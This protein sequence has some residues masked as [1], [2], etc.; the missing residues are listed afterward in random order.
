MNHIEELENRVK[1]LESRLHKEEKVRRV[2]MDRVENSVA[3]TGNSY[4]LFENNV[5]LHKKVEQRTWE[6]KSLLMEKEEI[7]T[8][9]LHEIEERQRAEKELSS[10]NRKIEALVSSIPL[11]MIEVSNEGIIRRWNTVAERVFRMDSSEVLGMEIYKC[12]IPWDREKIGKLLRRCCSECIAMTIKS[13]KFARA[14]EHGVLDLTVS[15][16]REGASVF[17]GLIILGADTTEHV[18]L[19]RQLAQSQKLE[20]IGQLAA[21]IAHEINTPAQ[22]VGDNTRFLDESFVDLERVHLLQ[23]RLLDRLRDGAPTD[24][25][26]RSIQETHKEMD[27]DFIRKEI[28]TA[29]KQSLEGLDHISRIVRSMKE[30]SHP[31]TDEKTGVDINRAIENTIN[32]ARNE[33]KYVSEVVTDLDSGLPLVPCLPGEFNQAILNMLINAAHAIAEK[34][35]KDSGHKGAITIATRHNGEFAEI[36]IRDNGAGIPEEVRPRIFD[37]FFTTKDVGKGTGQGLAISHSV[38]VGKHGG[39]ITFQSEVGEGTTFVLKLPLGDG[40]E[41]S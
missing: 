26:V 15:P 33:W 3:S 12:S 4:A 10:A 21:G 8:K 19:E 20:S 7:N 38:I 25:L 5:L 14:G 24:D 37:P 16:I 31:G 6:L 13:V 17:S 41:S 2:L 40:M 11:I 28:P 23:D 1:V 27:F 22:F 34:F 30:F 36:S 29:I 35:G 32:V 39:A 9:L 18:L